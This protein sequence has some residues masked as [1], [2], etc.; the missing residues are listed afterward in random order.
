MPTRTSVPRRRAIAAPTPTGLRLLPDDSLGSLVIAT[1]IAELRWTPDVA[2]LVVDRLA[3]DAVA[4][5]E[6]LGPPQPGHASRIRVVPD[7]PRGR[8]R[9]RLLLTAVLASLVAIVAVLVAGGGR[10]LAADAALGIR[11]EPFVDGLESPVHLTTAGDGSTELYI[12]E[13][14][15]RIRVA[16]ASGALRPEPFLDVSDGVIAGGERGLLG[17]AFHPAYPDDPRIFVNYTR[18]EDGGTIVSEFQVVDGLADPRSQRVLLSIAQPFPNH[19]GGTIAFDS[20]GHLLVGMGDGGGGG[21]PFDS[22]QDPQSLLGKLLR[23]DV[24]AEEPYGIP[25]DNGFADDPAYLPEIHASGL[26]NPW[27]FSVDPA[28]GHIYI[29]DVGQN[30][31]EEVSVLAGGAGGV[32]LGWNRFEGNECFSEPCDPDAH[33]A[34]AVTYTH[35]EGCTIVGGDVYRGSQQPALEG[36]YL[37]GDLCSGTIWAADAAAMLEGSVSPTPVG[38]MDGTLVAFG[39]DADREPLAVDHGGRILRVVAEDATASV[40]R[41]TRSLLSAAGPDPAAIAALAAEAEPEASAEAS[42]EPTF[43]PTGL[44]LRTVLVIDGLAEPVSV[45]GDGTGSG[46]LYIVERPGVI[47][48]IDQSGLRSPLLD[49][50]DRVSTDGERGLHAVAFHPDYED[51]GRFFVHYNDL[52]GNTRIEEYRTRR[53]RA[54]GRGRT[55]LEVGQPFIN[56]KGGPLMF[57]PD[58]HL[59]VALGDGGGSSPGDPMGFG[60]QKDS[61][62]AKVLRIDVDARRGYTIPRD[63]PYTSRRERRQYAPETWVYGLRDPRGASIDPETGDLWIGDAGQDRF[64]E[65]DLVRAGE[66]GANFGWSDME[67]V[68]CHLKVDCDAT[69]YTLPVHVYDQVTPDCGVVGGHVYRGEAI[70][71]LAGAYVFSDL[72]SGIIRAFDA[73]AVR[74]GQPPTVVALLDAPRG[75]RAIGTDDAGELYLTSLDGGVYRIEAESAP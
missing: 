26:R 15:G 18:R 59:Y 50:S 43:D 12:V 37:F 75:W 73:A 16:D 32:S 39:Q 38:V 20:A 19:N 5:P 42:P 45:T 54:A 33:L 65:I 11:L 60:Q 23:I 1:V 70:P 35:D 4:Y 51:N 3:R 62:L 7:D 55:I 69:D 53:G 14:R 34:P 24:D 28:G 52:D 47:Q 63:N 71:Q 10:A 40:A 66:G 56:N 13:Q 64:E 68:S 2:P 49:I 17:L 44:V 57:G 41:S 9:V 36:L 6:Q 48:V 58:G 25:P 72:C 67:G 74:E 46:L 31:I 30:A 27:R 29:A 22:G 61:L 21:D 8:R